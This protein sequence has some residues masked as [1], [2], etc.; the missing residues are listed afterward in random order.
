MLFF[1]L[2]EKNEAF[3]DLGMNNSYLAVKLYKSP[4]KPAEIADYE[5][6]MFRKDRIDLSNLPWDISFQHLIP[7]ID[8]ISHVKKIVFEVGMDIDNVKRSLK[9]LQFHGAIL[10]SDVFKFTNIYKLNTDLA[11]NLL[12]NT[13]LLNEMRTFSALPGTG[14]VPT[15]KQLVAFLLLLQ[16][17]KTIQQI[18]LEACEATTRPTADRK[19][20]VGDDQG[21]P[22][23]KGESSRYSADAEVNQPAQ[24]DLENLDISRLLAFSKAR[25]IIKRVH[26][27]PLY[28]P[29]P[30]PRNF[31]ANSAAALSRGSSGGSSTDTLSAL[32]AWQ[33]PSM[34]SLDSIIAAPRGAANSAFYLNPHAHDLQQ[35]AESQA[36][37]KT[38]SPRTG[39]M[40]MPR[41]A[42]ASS[43]FN[44]AA[45]SQQTGSNYYGGETFSGTSVGLS[46]VLS[47]ANSLNYSAGGAI[48]NKEIGM[49]KS[50][51]GP[52]RRDPQGSRDQDRPMPAAGL[53]AYNYNNGGA[54]D[55]SSGHVQQ[56]V[57]VPVQTRARFASSS[58]DATHLDRERSS[59]ITGAGAGGTSGTTPGSLA[60]QQTLHRLSSRSKMTAGQNFLH[61][62]HSAAGAALNATN[63]QAAHAAQTTSSWGKFEVR[64]VLHRLNG[65]EHMDAIC[66]RY[67]LSYEEIVSFPGVQLIYK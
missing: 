12:S 3:I 27:Y 37:E 45:G 63:N 33:H 60:K 48:L 59:T 7:H 25:G 4:V 46:G 44:Q 24:L 28:I 35:I 39:N 52:D 42:T 21:S 58:F 16:P 18:L 55:A 32:Q 26:E 19:D 40:P 57:E 20:S 2:N 13:T 10:L 51:F 17:N 53:S 22:E 43:G 54:H 6:P 41:T 29:P 1:Q 15:A 50:S 61:N 30:I 34:A 38:T 64:D 23:V 67:D 65:K 56:T 9:L 47:A 66:C 11:I 36:G 5:V 8:G 49:R 14:K 62:N 31:S